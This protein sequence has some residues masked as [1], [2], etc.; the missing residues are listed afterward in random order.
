[1]GS[2]DVRASGIVGAVHASLLSVVS[3]CGAQRTTSTASAP[4]ISRT[5]VQQ[6][7]VEA[8]ALIG[9]QRG[10][11]AVRIE[12]IERDRRR[13]RRTREKLLQPVERAFV[14]GAQVHADAHP[15]RAF[16]RSSR[17]A[18]LPECQARARF[19]DV[20]AAAQ[21]QRR[22][23]LQAWSRDAQTL[24]ETPSTSSTPV[25]SCS[26]RMAQ[27][28]PFRERIGA[29]GHHDAG[30][31]D[32]FAV[33]AALDAARSIGAQFLQA[34]GVFRERMAG[35]VKAQRRE[36]RGKQFVLGPL[37]DVGQLRLRGPRSRRRRP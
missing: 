7:L 37:L 18:A 28:S 1:M 20:D 9:A 24:R 30:D 4:H 3:L 27:R 26:V 35:N 33:A 10:H 31:G 14:H 17:A 34:R 2:P 11:R 15:R 12:Q 25:I 19:F 5:C 8:H 23:R 22:I 36:F 29:H 16:R 21:Q 32:L 6:L 13:A